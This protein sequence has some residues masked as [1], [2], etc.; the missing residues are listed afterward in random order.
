MTMVH[1][2]TD[3]QTLLLAIL[4][5]L[6]FILFAVVLFTVICLSCYFSHQKRKKSAK[7]MQ[8]AEVN[9]PSKS[10]EQDSDSASSCR[11]IQTSFIGG[12]DKEDIFKDILILY[13]TLTLGDVIGQGKCT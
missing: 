10:Q 8:F 5:P 2:D 12:S 1:I 11:Y 7:E 9:E 3:D 13:E 6:L 4:L